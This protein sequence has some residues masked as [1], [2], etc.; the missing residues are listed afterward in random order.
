MSDP[1]QPAERHFRVTERTLRA[2]LRWQ[3]PVVISTRG[4]LVAEGSY[5]AILQG[6]RSCVV[7]FSFSS[8]NDS[9]AKLTEPNAPRPS[10]LLRTMNVLARKGISVTARWQPYIMGLSEEPDVFVRRV[11]EAGARHVALEHLKIPLE[12]ANLW[13]QIK[14]RT[15][16]DF[17]AEYREAGAHRDGRELVLD[18]QHKLKLL[19]N[20]RTLTRRSGM[21]FGAADNEFQ[22]LSDTSCCCSGVDQF[23]GFENFFSHQI[24]F[25]VRESRGGEICYQTLA[26]EWTP[27]AK[28]D[29]FINSKSRVEGGLAMRDHIRNRWCD[30][31][32]AFN[33]RSFYGVESLEK[34]KGKYPVFTWSPEGKKLW[35]SQNSI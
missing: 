24:G 12:G 25:A 15:S 34:S 9:V 27:R 19:L 14:A 1:F 2:L 28:L 26:D 10:E 22:F 21:T 7:Q 23:S 13:Q 4:T 11:S 16:R 6:M 17:L 32:S 20:L 8:S 31:G 33:P 5:V 18:A 3:Y 30:P 35:Q 29:R